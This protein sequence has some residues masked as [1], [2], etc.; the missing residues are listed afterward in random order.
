MRP[1]DEAGGFVSQVLNGEVH[2]GPMG[3]PQRPVSREDAV[4]GNAATGGARPTPGGEGGRAVANPIPPWTPSASVAAPGGVGATGVA[5]FE[6]QDEA[7]LEDRCDSPRGLRAV[8]AEAV[9]A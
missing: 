7:P 9:C 8:A 4:V 1:I 5:P 3:P 6:P 2:Y